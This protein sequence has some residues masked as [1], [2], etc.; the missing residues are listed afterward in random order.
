MRLTIGAF[1]LAWA[2]VVPAT[3]GTSRAGSAASSAARRSGAWL[4]ARSSIAPGIGA[5][6]L[7]LEWVEGGAGTLSRDDE[8]F[9][10]AGEHGMAVFRHH[11]EI[12]DP[13][14]AA[15]RQIHAGLHGDHVPGEQ[16]RLGRGGQP[17]RLVD[18]HPDPVAEPVTE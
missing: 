8:V 12:L 17:R 7:R 6:P 3:A 11:H 2:V 1:V 4:R 9:G 10:S 18:L 13:H 14:A 5:L 15:A 16:R